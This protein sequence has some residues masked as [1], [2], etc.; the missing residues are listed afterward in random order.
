MPE[1]YHC[2][3]NRLMIPCKDLSQYNKYEDYIF[4]LYKTI[5]ESHSITYNEKPVTMKH[6]PPNYDER[7]G[8]YHIVC[9]NYKDT[10]DEQDRDPNLSRCERITW[11]AQI[12]SKCAKKDI[13]CNNLLVWENTR[14]SKC[15]IL[16][17]CPDI[18][19]LVVLGIRQDYYLLTT[20]YPV[21]PHTRE[22]LL[23]EYH[24]Y[25]ANDAS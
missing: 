2:V 6:R 5:Y 17:F 12:I 16:L 3:H 15:N 11:G 10:N 1:E 20:A 14:Y 22:K 24:K 19:Y 7:S 13:D 4:N 9:E 25:I 18:N 8:F 23:K 21:R